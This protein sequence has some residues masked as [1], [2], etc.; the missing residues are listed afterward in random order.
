MHE[1]YEN[2]EVAKIHPDPNNCRRPAS[3]EAETESLSALAQ[4]I[5]ELGLLAPLVVRS[6]P[7]IPGEWMLVS[8]HRRLAAC[9]QARIEFVPCLCHELTE[10]QAA[11]MQLVENLQRADINPIDEARAFKRLRDKFGLTSRQIGEKTGV[12]DRTVRNRLALLKLGPHT[13]EQIELGELTATTALEC[14]QR[15]KEAEEERKRREAEAEELL[16]AD[17]HA[18]ADQAEQELEEFFHPPKYKEQPIPFPVPQKPHNDSVDA[19]KPLKKFKVKVTFEID[20]ESNEPKSYSYPCLMS[21]DDYRTA[22]KI[23][24]RFYAKEDKQ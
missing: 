4:S 1:S 8:G 22:L 11:L 3:T 7:E 10:E 14:A 18:L 5:E 19:P 6:H 24:D 2:I 9:K 23:V 15:R 12:T 20:D 16:A 17:V 21:M 13:I